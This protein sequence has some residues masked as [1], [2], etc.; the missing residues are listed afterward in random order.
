MDRRRSRKVHTVESLIRYGAARFQRAGVWLGHG[1]ERYVDEAA[2]LVFYALGLDH[3][4]GAAVYSQPLGP[5]AQA[6]ALGLIERRIAERIPAAYLTHRMWF[7][8]HELYVDERVLVPRSP[9]A[10]LIQ[11]RF[12]PWIEPERVSSIIDIGT[13]SGCIAIAA[14]HAFAGALIVATDISPAALEV[15]RINVVRHG[16]AARV[17]LVESDVWSRVGEQRFDII[18]SNPPYVSASEMREL[19]AEY[20]REPALGLRAGADGLDVVRRI[21]KGAGRHLVPGGILIVEV[22][23]SEQSLARA[24]PSVPF[25]WLELE[26]G[27]GGVLL[28]TAA[29]VAAHSE[30]FC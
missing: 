10:E 20:L 18:V 13:G 30:D 15:A 19:P 29:E 7:A 17:R 26:R 11:Q 12:A 3:E 27:G 2:E 24:F 25:T 8:G 1:T 14:A 22:G 4:D 6:R 28:L 23:N 21:L 5:V 9:I 16:L